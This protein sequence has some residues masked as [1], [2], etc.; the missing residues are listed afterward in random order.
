MDAQIFPRVA[1]L[2]V[3]SRSLT[4]DPALL[5][6]RPYSLEIVKTIFII[7]LKFDIFHPYFLMSVQ[8]IFHCVL[9]TAAKVKDPMYSKFP[10]HNVITSY[11]GQRSFQSAK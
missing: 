9:G 7:I 2:I 11:V 3:R 8:W 5:T 10:V 6:T 4:W 1:E